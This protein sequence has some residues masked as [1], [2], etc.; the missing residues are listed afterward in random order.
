MRRTH[1]P[2][3]PS[4]ATPPHIR[5]LAVQRSSSLRIPGSAS[6]VGLPA[7]L[8][9]PCGAVQ[10]APC[11]AIEKDLA[12]RAEEGAGQGDAQVHNS[13]ADAPMPRWPHGPM[14]QCPR[15]LSQL[16]LPA[17]MDAGGWLGSTGAG[18]HCATWG[19]M[20]ILIAGAARSVVCLHCT[21]QSVLR[22][23]HCYVRCR[24]Q[25]A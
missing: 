16:P 9:K 22:K 21:V 11:R 6:S 18:G 14:P 19:W 2:T 13:S 3:I 1:A 15:H 25:K 5:S 20:A 10:C 23:L 7:F 8:R 12:R 24:A 4:A 17:H